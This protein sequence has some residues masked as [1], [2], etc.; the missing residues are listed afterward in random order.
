MPIGLPEF[1]AALFDPQ[2]PGALILKMRGS[3]HGG[4]GHQTWVFV[5]AD[6]A[7]GA[8]EV[9]HVLWLEPL[10]WSMSRSAQHDVSAAKELRRWAFKLGHEA[11]DRDNVR[12][13]RQDRV[14]QSQRGPVPSLHLVCVEIAP[15]CPK[16]T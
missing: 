10:T 9:Q 7:V 4:L 16:R 11:Q 12:V 15:P 2:A 8:L 14:E 13:P 3:E 1:G 5:F 6:E